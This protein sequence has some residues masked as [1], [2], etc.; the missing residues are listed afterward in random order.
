MTPIKVHNSKSTLEPSTNKV[1]V[2]KSSGKAHLI[3]QPDLMDNSKR[4][5]SVV[6][7]KSNNQDPNKKGAM[8]KKNY[9]IKKLN[10]VNIH[11]NL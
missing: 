10:L 7:P 1:H 11:N 2:H 4:S 9:N 8:E 6:N 5:V 3:A